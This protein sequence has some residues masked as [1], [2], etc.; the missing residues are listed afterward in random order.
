MLRVKSK[1]YSMDFFSADVVKYDNIII[2]RI[3]GSNDYTKIREK[4]QDER[5]H[6]Q[7]GVI[8]IVVPE[9]IT[10]PNVQK[11]SLE[12]LENLHT[13]L[14]FAHGHDVP[15]QEF[16]LYE[17][18]DSK[19]ILLQHEIRPVWTGEAGASSF[20][21]LF[22]FDKFL[23]TT[24]PLLSDPD[25]VSKTNVTLAI[26]YY[27]HARNMGVMDVN[28]L[29]LWLSL[30]TIVNAY[31]ANNKK[32][33]LLTKEEWDSLKDN[34]KKYLVTIGKEDVYSKL[35]QKIAFLRGGTIKEKINYVLNEPTYQLGK[36]S[37]EVATIYDQMRVPLVHG[38]RIDWMSN[39]FENIYR[40]R[41][42]LE[43]VLFKTIGFYDNKMVH[44][45]IKEDDLSAR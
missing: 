45:A 22:G 15:I 36:Y 6:Y 19:E 43:K 5:K 8:T 33:L 21:V 4:I 17:V 35:L 28:F 7:T 29:L 37:S 27:N 9:V 10:V 2:E 18:T 16:M 13:L 44:P 1:I 24:M 34:C 23:E 26:L 42:L 14:S 20:N 25:F 31:Y 30:E 12:L 11:Y 38:Q 32:D 39:S 41:R 3:G 40:L